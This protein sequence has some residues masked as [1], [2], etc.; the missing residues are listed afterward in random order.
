MA[1]L[2]DAERRRA[3]RIRNP[4]RRRQF[5][6]GR[7]L[8]RMHLAHLLDR[9][10]ASLPFRRTVDAPPALADTEIHL[11]LSH[12]AEVCLCVSSAET[13]VGCDVEWMRPRPRFREIAAHY[14]HERESAELARGEDR[15]GFYRLW[16]LKEASCKA[17]GRGIGGGLRS[18]AFSLR[19]ALR[20]LSAP[21]GADWT[22]AAANLTIRGK[23]YSLAVAVPGRVPPESFSVSRYRAGQREPRSPAWQFADISGRMA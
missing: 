7:W 10:P 9:D 5:A 6:C 21:P 2:S 14:F 17:R 20:C 3:G 15:P 12:S 8:L 4:R 23:E 18:P 19:P 13:A 1:I 22:F 11:G 16:T